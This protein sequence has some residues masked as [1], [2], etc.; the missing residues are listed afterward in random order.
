MGDNRKVI[1]AIL[2]EQSSTFIL[3]IAFFSMAILLNPKGEVNPS[4]A[5]K[6]SMAVMVQN[7]A[8]YVILIES[9]AILDILLDFIFR[10]STIEKIITAMA[11]GTCDY[12][13]SDNIFNGF[14]KGK[15]NY[16]YRN[17][18]LFYYIERALEIT[19]I[20][21]AIWLDKRLTNFDCEPAH[22]YRIKMLRF[23]HLIVHI[24]EIKEV[25]SVQLQID[26]AM[27]QVEQQKFDIEYTQEQRYKKQKKLAILYQKYTDATEQRKKEVYLDY[28]ADVKKEI[29]TLDQQLAEQI[30]TQQFHEQRH[31]LLEEEIEQRKQQMDKTN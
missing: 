19:H 22:T 10:F 6:H 31:K 24:E 18:G 16:L 12:R 26:D 29:E 28:I 3:L 20:C 8:P 1:R 9:K 23:S 4:F 15:H 17:S 11:I 7:I 27:G 13:A 25:Q 2:L 5:S 14:K 30:K 21:E